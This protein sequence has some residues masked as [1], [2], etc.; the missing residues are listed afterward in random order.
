MHYQFR[1]LSGSITKG[2]WGPTHRPKPL[3]TPVCVVYDRDNPSHNSPYPMQ[4]VR[5][6]D[7]DNLR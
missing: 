4:L 7:W 5:V 3:G 2:R 6:K 1:V